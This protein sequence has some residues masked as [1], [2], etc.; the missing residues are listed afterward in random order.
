MLVVTP[1]NVQK[2]LDL[3][4][5]GQLASLLNLLELGGAKLDWCLNLPLLSD[6]FGLF[7]ATR[8]QCS[9]HYTCL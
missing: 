3:P 5:M 4:S 2:E 6:S 9:R 7:N 8:K 1:P